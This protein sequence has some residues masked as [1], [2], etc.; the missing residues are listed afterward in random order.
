MHDLDPRG[1][2]DWGGSDREQP[3]DPNLDRA[4]HCGMLVAACLCLASFAPPALM[5]LA[6]AGLLHSAAIAMVI[7]AI[8]E[9]D[10]FRAPTLTRWDEAAACLMISLLIRL[11]AP[12]EAATSLP[13]VQP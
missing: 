11:L 10:G 7:V 8:L 12:M 4:L 2:R 1:W 13:A 9:E 6:A 5:P 3:G